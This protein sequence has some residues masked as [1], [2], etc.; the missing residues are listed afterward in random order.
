LRQTIMYACTNWVKVISNEGMKLLDSETQSLHQKESLSMLTVEQLT[1]ITQSTRAVLR[2]SFQRRAVLRA[3]AQVSGQRD[4]GDADDELA[5]MEESRELHI[6]IAEVI[7]TLFKTHGALYFPVY[8]EL[9]QEIIHN[10]SQLHC[11]REDR[12]FSLY[13]ISDV[14]EYGLGRSNSANERAQHFLGLVMDLLIETC[15]DHRSQSD[16]DLVLKRVSAY[17]IGLAAELYPVEFVPYVHSALKALW[18]LVRRGDEE[19]PGSRGATTDNAVSAVGIILEQAEGAGVHFSHEGMASADY[20]WGEWLAYLPL[21]DDLE[22]GAKVVQQLIR[23]VR[24]R[25]PSLLSRADRLIMTASVLLLIIDSEEYLLGGVQSPLNAQCK[26]SLRDL[27]VLS[28]S[29]EGNQPRHGPAHFLHEQEMLPQLMQQW[30]APGLQEKLA[31]LVKEMDLDLV[32]GHGGEESSAMSCSFFD[33]SPLATAPILDVL[34][35]KR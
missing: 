12:H 20:I 16:T 34:M 15:L 28:L 27:V 18:M 32:R 19:G 33:G 23:L 10:A 25:H 3:E 1:K 26:G 21:K 6:N 11:L 8:L 2:D 9:W 5:F 24:G 29:S 31:L 30:I 35:R 13:V 22:E 17:S 4:E 7:G 14:I